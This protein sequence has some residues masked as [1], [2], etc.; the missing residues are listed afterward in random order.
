MAVHLPEPNSECALFCSPFLRIKSV[1]ETAE[2]RPVA[3]GQQHSAEPITR[4]ELSS[5][6]RTRSHASQRQSSIL[7]RV[8]AAENY[9]HLIYICKINCTM[10]NF[11]I[12][13]VAYW[14]N[15]NSR[16][17]PQICKVQ[18]IQK[19]TLLNH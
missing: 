14:Y 19:C 1:T 10:Q 3:H 9:S 17:Y 2:T 16:K 5:S 6:T 4:A 8:L 12:F 18:F 11:K 7:S 15:D 13:S